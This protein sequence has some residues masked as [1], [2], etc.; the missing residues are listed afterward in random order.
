MEYLL[1]FKELCHKIFI[2]EEN[3]AAHSENSGRHHLYQVT[4]VNI[5]GHEAN[6]NCTLSDRKRW[7]KLKCYSCNVPAKDA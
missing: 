3:W 5:T 6:Q 2:T 4:Q 7:E 1:S